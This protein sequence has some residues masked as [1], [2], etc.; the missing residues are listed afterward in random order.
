MLINVYEPIPWVKSALICRVYQFLWCKYSHHGRFQ[1]T[2]A[3]SLNTWLGIDVQNQLSLY[4]LYNSILSLSFETILLSPS[5]GT[6]EQNGEVIICEYCPGNSLLI[7]L[8]C[9]TLLITSDESYL[10]FSLGLVEAKQLL[11]GFRAT[12]SHMNGDLL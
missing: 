6:I 10:S 5:K 8:L 4:H 12:G 3:R 2:N 11:C 1:V 7:S 9:L